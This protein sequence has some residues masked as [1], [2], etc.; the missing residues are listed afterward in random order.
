M[1]GKPEVFIHFKYLPNAFWE[2][3]PVPGAVG[4]A[5]NRTDKVLLPWHL[6]E[7]GTRK[8]QAT[9]SRMLWRLLHALRAT[10]QQCD[11][12]GVWQQV[13]QGDQR[14]SVEAVNPLTT[15]ESQLCQGQRAKLSSGAKGTGHR[16]R[17]RLPKAL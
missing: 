7:G 16:E 5:E 3:R 11:N 9:E 4:I 10:K 1:I 8:K 15:R 17:G 6:P 12:P 2:L 13:L 14:K